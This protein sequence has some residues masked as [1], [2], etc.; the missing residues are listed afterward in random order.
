MDEREKLLRKIVE[1]VCEEREG[2]KKLLSNFPDQVNEHRKPE[3]ISPEKRVTD[4]AYK[5]V[6]GK[7]SL[8][9]PLYL[10]GH[11]LLTEL[12]LGIRGFTDQ[13][14]SDS[15]RKLISL[16]L[17]FLLH[18]RENNVENRYLQAAVLKEL[19]RRQSEYSK[20]TEKRND[21]VDKP[22]FQEA[23]RAN[24][25]GYDTVEDAVQDLI[26]KPR[27]SEYEPDTLWNWAREVWPTPPRKGRPPKKGNNN[28]R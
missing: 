1:P 21:R 24:I 23:V 17:L 20:R 18:E 10:E 8:N 15:Y 26:I 4:L 2:W 12:S 14:G 19:T 27:F 5:L 13:W 11:Q 22:V 6:A 3:I 28:N 9:E 7:G 25:E 16:I